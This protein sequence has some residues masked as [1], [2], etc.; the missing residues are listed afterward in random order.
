MQIAVFVFANT[1]KTSVKFFF[2]NISPAETLACSGAKY[3][4]SHEVSKTG[5]PIWYNT[6]V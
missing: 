3:H 6:H 4:F 2:L 1:V 5:K